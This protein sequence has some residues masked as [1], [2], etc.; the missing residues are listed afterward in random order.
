MEKISGILPASARITSVDMKNSGVARSGSPSFGRPQGVSTGAAI[1]SNISKLGAERHNEM[2]AL[3]HP[4]QTGPKD[5]NVDIVEQISRDFFLKPSAPS[6]TDV[7]IESASIDYGPSADL[8][9]A[10][11][12]RGEDMDRPEIGGYLDVS[13]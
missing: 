4:T 13:A 12:S 7:A 8:D 6:A 1:Q 5:P 9:P 10:T 11:D 3:R 2:M